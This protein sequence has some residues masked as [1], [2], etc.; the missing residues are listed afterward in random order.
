[1][2][3]TKKILKKIIIISAV[4]IVGITAVYAWIV[5]DVAPDIQGFFRIGSD[6][7]LVLKLQEAE[8]TLV[9]LNEVYGLGFNKMNLSETSSVDAVNIFARNYANYYQDQSG[10]EI[11]SFNRAS[12]IVCDENK[13]M[14]G[15]YLEETVT[16]SLKYADEGSLYYIYFLNGVL[17]GASRVETCFSQGAGAS[18]SDNGL[19]ALRVAMYV[20]GLCS[21]NGSKVTYDEKSYNAILFD[22]TNKVPKYAIFRN[23]GDEVIEEA[24]ETTGKYTV[25]NTELQ[26]CQEVDGVKYGTCAPVSLNDFDDFALD[27]GDKNVILV[28]DSIP[29]DNYLF[30]LSNEYRTVSITLRIWLEGCS[31]YCV[32]GQIVPDD[33]VDLNLY[34][35]AFQKTKPIEE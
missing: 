13:A 21:L 25:A 34:F 22:K 7:G 17:N 11:I 32:D 27:N 26:I 12:R 19:R 1:V 5:G 10:N 6:S 35:V 31:K 33:N 15:Q 23:G 18:T 20:D 24:V 16:L 8:G 3:T 14:S 29:N 28:G 9:N 2:K 4:I 30:V